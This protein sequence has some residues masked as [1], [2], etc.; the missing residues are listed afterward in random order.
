M[1]YQNGPRSKMTRLSGYN[2][3]KSLLETLDQ[4]SGNKVAN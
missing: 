1:A 2:Y 4:C 3:F